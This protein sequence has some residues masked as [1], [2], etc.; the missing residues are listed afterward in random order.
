MKRVL[1]TIIAIAISS[2][3]SF[4]HTVTGT[5]K[6]KNGEELPGVTV[7]EQGTMNYTMTSYNGDFI[8]DVSTPAA[9]LVFS[10]I[11]YYDVQVPLNGRTTIS[12]VMY[13]DGSIVIIEG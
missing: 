9:T 6:D 7:Y 10:L 3:L 11:G 1:I 2:I 13:E 12:V 8:I 5:V 4:A